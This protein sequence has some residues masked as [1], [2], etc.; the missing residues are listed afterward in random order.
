MID[1]SAGNLVPSARMPTTSSRRPVNVSRPGRVVLLHLLPAAIAMY[2]GN[3]DVDEEL[4]DDFARTVAEG[5]LRRRIEFDDDT[6]LIDGDHGIERAVE[7]PG[8]AR[9]ALVNLPLHPLAREELSHLSA[10]GVEHP[11]QIVVG[12]ADAARAELE[13]AEHFPSDGHR[14]R[15]RA[16][17]SVGRRRLQPR[18]I[19]LL[20]DIGDPLRRGIR[21]YVT[22]KPFAGLESPR[23]ADVLEPGKPAAGRTSDLG[24]AQLSRAGIHRPPQ[25]NVPTE[26]G[27]DDVDDSAGGFLGGGRVREHASH[28]V[29]GVAADEH[30]RAFGNRRTE[31]QPGR[32]DDRH[33]DLQKDEVIAGAADGVRTEPVRGPPHGDRQSHD[34]RGGGPRRAET[35]RG[36]DEEREDDVVE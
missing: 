35:N 6:A 34:V 2:L 25:S 11:Q 18:N 7:H 23:Q 17:E 26:I 21:P 19:A 36:A 22:R 33:E 9:L 29:L 30:G 3:E 4:S 5:P 10:D 32:R 16:V 27:V 24:T 15:E 8:L 31:Q 28:C 12:P 13:D 14:E 1:S 20:R